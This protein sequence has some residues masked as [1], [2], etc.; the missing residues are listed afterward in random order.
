[1]PFVFVFSYFLVPQDVDSAVFY[2]LREDNFA[3]LENNISGSVLKSLIRI[4]D[5]S[6]T[7]T[8][9]RINAVNKKHSYHET[10]P[11]VR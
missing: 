5:L 4:L 3:L 9:E 11:T 10:T 2:D 8:L 6:A 1:M 7:C